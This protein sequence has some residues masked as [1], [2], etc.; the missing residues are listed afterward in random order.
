MARAG[1]AATAASESSA[2][3]VRA[4]AVA[5]VRAG[6]ATPAAPARRR[7]ATAPRRRTR[8]APP[9]RAPRPAS[10]VGVRRR[11]AL[12]VGRFV[13][14]R[15]QGLLDRLLRGRLWVGFVGALLAGIVFLNVSL[16]ELNRDIARTS[17]QAAALDRQNSEIRARLSALDSSELIQR[18]AT[19][20]GM[21][22]PAPREYR[23][24]RARPSIDAR[25]AARRAAAPTALAAAPPTATT[26]PAAAATA[27]PAQATSA[28]ASAATTTA[29]SPAAP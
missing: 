27:S 14:A 22:M 2:A 28:V 8:H 10:P 23:Y 18:L 29:A 9:R 7:P 20:Q 24:L 15:T 26:T 19:A 6:A 17:V 11:V 25:L 1:A 16:L 3:A 4:R 5:A 21:E 12:A 13:E